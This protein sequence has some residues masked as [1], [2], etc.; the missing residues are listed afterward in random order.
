VALE[1]GVVNVT[2]R[3]NLGDGM[4]H[5]LADAQLALRASRRGTLVVMAGHFRNPNCRHH[6]RMRVIQYS[7][8][9]VNGGDRRM[10]RRCGA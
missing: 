1:V 2:L 8:P 9:K 10:P 4:A 7:L 5:G 6:P 3:Q